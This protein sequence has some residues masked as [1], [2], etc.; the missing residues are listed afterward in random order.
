MSYL[1]VDQCDKIPWPHRHPL[2]RAT[3]DLYQ[4][5][6]LA[7]ASSWRWF[8]LRANELGA[9]FDAALTICVGVVLMRYFDIVQHGATAWSAAVLGT[10]LTFSGTAVFVVG[11]YRLRN[12]DYGN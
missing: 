3:T 10:V 7:A 8:K 6:G 4:C 12:T 2:V 1:H 9:V 5:E 11:F